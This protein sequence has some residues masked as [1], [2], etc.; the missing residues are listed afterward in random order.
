MT[1]DLQP[2]APDEAVDL[3]ID[4]RRDDLSEKSLQNHRYRLDTFVEFCEERGITNLNDLTARELHRYRVWRREQDISTITL[5][6]NLAT[7]RVFL[8]FCAQID[9]VESGLREKVVLPEIDAADE[10]RDEKLEGERARQILDYLDQFHYASRNHVVLGILWHTGI[11][12]GTLRALDV[13]DFDAEARCLDVRHR[14][15]EGTPLKNQ[16]AAERSIAVGEYW[17]SVISDYIE[18]T[19]DDVSDAHGRHPLV[20]ST[21]GRL[22][23]GAIRE[24]IYRITQP[25]VLGDCPH[26]RDPADCEARVYGHGAD[27]PSSRSPHGIRRGAITEH[28]RSETPE[29]VVSDRMNVTGDVLEKHYDRRTERE[30]MELRRDHLPNQR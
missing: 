9:G 1:D 27:C 26:D 13:G 15:E 12:L 14:P 3:Y 4:H 5:K 10:A 2:L 29:A 6:S 28:L 8:Q 22:S 25:C 21:H 7:L 16:G 19:R 11:R 17:V 20:T 18:H 23:E 24:A 30:K